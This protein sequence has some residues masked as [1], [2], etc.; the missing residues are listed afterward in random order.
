MK[1]YLN[2]CWDYS[3]DIARW[4]SKVSTDGAKTEV[5]AIGHDSLLWLT[6]HSYRPSKEG[7]RAAATGASRY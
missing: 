2:E 4:S 3:F 5:G 1:T 7:A 6:H